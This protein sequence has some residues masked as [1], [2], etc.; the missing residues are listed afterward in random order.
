MF[1]ARFA[2]NFEVGEELVY[3]VGAG[4][5][6]GRRLVTMDANINLDPT[7]PCR[8]ATFRRRKVVTVE[9]LRA[10]WEDECAKTLRCFL[11]LFP[12]PRISSEILMECVEK[13]KGR[14][15]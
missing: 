5:L 15:F 7:D 3:E 14:K 11:E 2:E 1:L 6:A 13:F 10:S 4:P 12:G 8:A 9:T